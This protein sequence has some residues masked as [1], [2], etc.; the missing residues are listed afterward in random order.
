M[1]SELVPT[2]ENSMDSIPADKVLKRTQLDLQKRFPIYY[3]CPN[4][5]RPSL[6]LGIPIERLSIPPGTG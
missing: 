6:G 3:V 5:W 4:A 1:M 2:D